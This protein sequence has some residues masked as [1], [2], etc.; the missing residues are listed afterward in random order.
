MSPRINKEQLAQA[1]LEQWKRMT[2][3]EQEL[4][5]K[6]Y[7]Y[8]AGVDEAGRGP[9]AGPVVAA[10]VIF[11]EGAY[12]PGLNDSKKLSEKRRF[13]LE[14]QIKE[15]SLAWSC[16]MVNHLGIDRLNILNATKLAMQRALAKLTPLPDFVLID[17]NTPLQIFL[18]QL[19]IVKGDSLSV[20]IAAASIL[21]KCTR[22]RLMLQ[23]DQQYPQY[24]FAKHKGYPTAQHKQLLREYGSC[25]IHRRSFK[26]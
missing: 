12:L 4:S 22:D 11:P 3:Y 25:P 23:L 24:Q 6:G 5:D 1:Q 13:E 18:P 9:L 19:C 15:Q 14:E 8:I 26:Y 17:G 20:S 2:R 10:A 21:A 7:R 16:G